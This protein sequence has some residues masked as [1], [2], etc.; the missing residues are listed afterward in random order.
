MSDIRPFRRFLVEYFE[1]QGHGGEFALRWLVRFR[2]QNGLL[3]SGAVI[4]KRTPGS[5]RPRLYFNVPK[6]ANWLATSDQAA[7]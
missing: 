7:A 6:F 2:A 1:P 5:S 3:A 4:E